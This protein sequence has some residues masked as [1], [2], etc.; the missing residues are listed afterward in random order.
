MVMPL[1]FYGVD[2]SLPAIQSLQNTYGLELER[3]ENE[4]Q[5]TAMLV[6]YSTLYPH[7]ECGI[8]LKPSGRLTSTFRDLHQQGGR[9]QLLALLKFIVNRL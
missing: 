9:E 2:T 1:G 6:A 4:H 5:H 3:L 8:E 7:N